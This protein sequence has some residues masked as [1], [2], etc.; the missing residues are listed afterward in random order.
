ME[1]SPSRTALVTSLMRALHSRHHPSPLLNDTWG[2]RLVPS[3]ERERMRERILARMDEETRTRALRAPDTVLDDF[4]SSNAAFPGVVIRS[5]YAEDALREATLRGVRQ[6]VLIGAGFDS[7]ALR[8]PA[9]SDGL[10]IFEVDHP[11]TQG[12]KIQRIKDC[13]ISLPPT[14]HFLAADLASEDLASVL[15]R[16]SFRRDEPA[17]FSWLGVTVY[18]TRQANLATL[19]SVA[20]V[21]APGSELVFT[22]VDQSEFAAGGARSP[23]DAN[24][25]AVAAMGEPYLSGF[26]PKEIANDLMNV[27]LELIED[28]DGREMSRRYGRTGSNPLQPAGSLHIVLARIPGRRIQAEVTPPPA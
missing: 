27:G 4:L 1:S 10:D 26:D 12:F 24:A 8:R 15:A 23:D 5:R 11:A 9:F 13:G 28:L 19:R 14:V 18:L 3:S 6:Y 22:Y 17:F 21:G 16:S 20:S 25:R 7:F 2:D